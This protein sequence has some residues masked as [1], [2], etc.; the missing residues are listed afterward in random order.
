MLDVLFKPKSV[1]VI[2]ASNKEFS[3]GNSVIAN[4]QTYGYKGD[5]YPINPT[6]P[7]VRGLRAYRSLLEVPG[8]VDVAHI[9]LPSKLVPQA[10]RECG[11]KGV[12]AAII[13][14]AGFKEMGAEGEA[15]QEE[16]L[17]IARKYGVRVLGPNCQGIINTA[18]DVKAYCNFTN[19]YPKP[20]S[21]SVVALSGGVGALIM[22]GLVDIGVGLRFYASNGNACDVS[23]PEIVRYLG[24]DPQTKAIV[25][26]TE[27]FADAAEFLQAAREVTKKKPILAMKAGRTEQGAKAASS[28]TGSLAGVDRTTEQIFEKTGI[29]SFTN[30][31]DMIRAA[32]AFASQSIPRGNRVGIITN[33]GGPAV[34]ATDVLVAQGLDVPVLSNRSNES[35]R[36]ALLPQAAV[37]NPIDVV[38]TA[39]PAHFRAALDIL[40]DDDGIDSIFLNFVT[41]SFSDTQAIAREIVAVSQR[42]RKPLVCNFM[43]DLAQERFQLTQ[44]ILLEGGVPCY[45]LPSDAAQALGALARYGRMQRRSIGE[46]EKCPGVDSARAR[47]II[48]AASRAGRHVLSAEE[49]YG[50]FEAYGL[51]VA[52]WRIAGTLDEALAAA[53]A[54][55]YPVVVKADC[56]ALDHKS[57]MG[58]VAVNLNDAGA[59]RAT[60]VDMQARLRHLGIKFLIQK[61]MAGGQEMI[62]GATS[63]QG[64]GHLVM[65]GLGGI[66]VEVLKD[67]VFKLAPLTRDE[68]QEMLSSIKAAA[69]LDGVRG[70]PALDK[71]GLVDILLRL[72]MLL[73]DLPMIQEMDMNPV[74][75]FEKSVFAVDGRIRI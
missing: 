49:V 40:N 33:T 23:I 52:P 7:E 54:I 18:P 14:S 25:L 68:A 11:E 5:V 26:Y 41:P 61:F 32:M 56:E 47:D 31:G 50:I 38:A 43:T 39:G 2:G 69:L 34:I 27:G 13:N 30:E 71:E 10:M 24:N 48:G 62:I 19:T 45:A 59:V 74:I 1:A 75:A 22:Q 6:S 3:I 55:G 67:V 8:A 36:G 16:F 73:D 72:S 37:E 57:D 21:I 29:L 63:A 44:R 64:L 4:L 65:F 28:H 15:L 42:G 51:P 58:G 9:V 20:G 46:V 12:K 35:L 70:K 53:E 17:Q 60:L 66:Y